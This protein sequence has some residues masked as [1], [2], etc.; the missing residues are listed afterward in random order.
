M[1]VVTVGLLFS[2]DAISTLE[3]GGLGLWI[4]LSSAAIG[5]GF[6]GRRWF[7]AL[8]S[9]RL[10][11]LPVICLWLLPV[12]LLPSLAFLALSLLGLWWTRRGRE[13]PV[14]GERTKPGLIEELDPSVPAAISIDAVRTADLP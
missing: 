14:E 1:L 3:K 7:F 8:E 5:A 4:L 13:H 12:A 9:L 10:I 11:A 2:G 6:E